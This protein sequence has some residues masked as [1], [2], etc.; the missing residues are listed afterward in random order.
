MWNRQ[1]NIHNLNDP[2]AHVN[3]RITT[4]LGYHN[5]IGQWFAKGPATQKAGCRGASALELYYVRLH[6]PHQIEGGL[7]QRTADSSLL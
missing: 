6:H 1:F 7:S 2:L 3:P 4:L 5:G